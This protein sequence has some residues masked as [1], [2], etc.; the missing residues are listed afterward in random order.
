MESG[1]RSLTLEGAK[2]ARCRGWSTP[3][4]V[5]PVIVPSS[6]AAPWVG[7]AEPAPEG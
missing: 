3:T 6:V 2:L 7:F 4:P 1:R 5:V